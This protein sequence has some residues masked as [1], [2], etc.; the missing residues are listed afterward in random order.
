MTNP[1][2]PFEVVTHT[3]KVLHLRE[4]AGRRKFLFIF[5]R[6][7]PVFLLLLLSIAAATFILEGTNGLPVLLLIFLAFTILVIALLLFFKSYL[8]EI[9]V[10]MQEF[11]LTARTVSGEKKQFIP[12]RDCEKITV[13]MT[14]GRG[15]GIYCTLILKSG[16]KNTLLNIPRLY[17]SEE[18]KQAISAALKELTG[19]PVTD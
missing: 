15:G 4:T 18:K 11:E 1:F 9:R 7:F 12:F 10:A 16:K 13:Y 6:V 5:F 19:L 14:G 17:M 3:A 2:H 8:V